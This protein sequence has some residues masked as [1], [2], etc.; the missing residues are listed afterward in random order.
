M[1]STDNFKEGQKAATNE[2]K[3]Q[4]AV[5]QAPVG[6]VIL[7]GKDMVVEMANNTYLSLVDFKEDDFVGKSIYESL[8]DVKQRVSHLFD[9]VLATGKPYHGYEFEFTINRYE[10]KEQTYFNFVYQPLREEDNTISGI[11]VIATEVTD[12][13]R[14]RKAFEQKEVQFRKLVSQS[15]IAMAILRG[16]D[17]VIEIANNA[18]LAIWRKT[19]PK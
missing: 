2:K 7:K 16:H 15:P 18:M 3:F 13:V 9:H 4:N 12:Q 5:M 19:L 10:K 6:M 8:P 1:S 14:T 11:I 17:H